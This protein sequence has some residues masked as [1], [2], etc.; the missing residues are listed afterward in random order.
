MY[1]N[2]I[3]RTL[4]LLAALAAFLMLLPVFILATFILLV[5]NRGKPFFSQIRPGRNGR[6][7]KIFKFKTMTDRRDGQGELLPDADRLTKVGLVVRK[8]SIDEIP[9]LLNVIKGDMS[10]VGPRPLLVE[11]LPL[12]NEFQARRHEVRPGITG[13][14]QINGRNALD[15]QKRFELD[16]YYVD[17]MSFWMDLRILFLT[18]NK[19]FIREGISSKSSSTMEKFRGN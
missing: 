10:L 12:Y 13:W 6:L 4:D 18:I 9:Q 7:F 1:K 19:V 8:L 3:K 11:Y 16:V 2:F 14:A 17:Q 5:V 15:W